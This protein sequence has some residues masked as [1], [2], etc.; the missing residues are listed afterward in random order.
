MRMETGGGRLEA[1][2]PGLLELEV[3]HDDPVEVDAVHEEHPTRGGED[4]PGGA[5]GR[6][7]EKKEEGH[8]EVADDEEDREEGPGAGVAVDE[9]PSFLGDVGVPLEEVL[10]EGDVTPEDGEGEKEHAHDVVVL[11][12]EEAAEVAGADEAVGAEGWAGGTNEGA[13]G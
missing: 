1:G 13:K 10:A 8:K 5:F 11:D 7:G 9:E 6:L 4:P 3:R 2:M 12:G